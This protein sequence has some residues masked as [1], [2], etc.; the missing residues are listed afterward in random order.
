VE[1]TARAVL[2][3]ETLEPALRRYARRH[4]AWFGPHHWMISDFATARPFKPVEKLLFKAIPHDPVTAERFR[5]IAERRVPA[6]SL[7]KPRTLARAARV[8]ASV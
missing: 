5:A 7:L 4:A 1:E 3:E 8:A 6:A 2:G